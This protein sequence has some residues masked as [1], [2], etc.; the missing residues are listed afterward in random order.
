MIKTALN[1]KDSLGIESITMEAFDHSLRA[2]FAIL[3]DL[4]PSERN[5]CLQELVI[6]K[7]KGKQCFHR[8]L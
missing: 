7:L 5:I 2:S 8:S 1:L 3:K 4:T 6:N